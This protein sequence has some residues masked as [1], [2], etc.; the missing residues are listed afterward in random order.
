M[1][2]NDASDFYLQEV[3]PRLKFNRLLNEK[4]SSTK[5]TFKE[6]P[7][8]VAKQP[9]ELTDEQD[10]DRLKTKVYQRSTL[11][12]ENFNFEAQ[13][14]L[15]ELVTRY[16]LVQE[17][18]LFNWYQKY[19][20]LQT[21]FVRWRRPKF[22]LFE[23]GSKA[24]RLTSRVE[25][26]F[27]HTYR[28]SLQLYCEEPP[29]G[30]ILEFKSNYFERGRSVK[31]VRSG[32]V[33]SY[34]WGRPQLGQPRVTGIRFK[35]KISRPGQLVFVGRRRPKPYFPR[36]M[37]RY[38]IFRTIARAKKYVPRWKKKRQLTKVWKYRLKSWP[39]RG[40]RLKFRSIRRRKFSRPLTFNTQA[41][42][43]KLFNYF[44]RPGTRPSFQLQRQ[45]F[46]NYKKRN[47]LE[48]LWF[49]LYSSWRFFLS[50]KGATRVRIPYYSTKASPCNTNTRRWFKKVINQQSERTLEKRI[51]TGFTRPG[52]KQVYALRRAWLKDIFKDRALL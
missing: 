48:H 10:L 42:Y 33:L 52:I 9:I 26:Y 22:N 44:A 39:Y 30:S 20:T 23:L 8:F 12:S 15:E 45:I 7:Y 5:R 40:R 29:Q 51:K 41:E 47:T 38:R 11:M 1:R 49:F 43:R 2:L 27:L 50:P 31:F 24:E 3:Q 18:S 17:R 35:V 4:Q 37:Y 46:F 6:K 13:P 34:Q 21:T 14:F 19:Q 32:L 16:D 28:N 36:W 25:G